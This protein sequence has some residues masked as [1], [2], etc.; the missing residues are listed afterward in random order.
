MIIIFL[1][2]ACGYA[3]VRYYV[4]V[5]ILYSY[6][7][8]VCILL[9]VCVSVQVSIDMYVCESEEGESNNVYLVR[10]NLVSLLSPS[11]PLQP[12]SPPLPV[13]LFN[14]AHKC[15]LQQEQRKACLQYFS[16]IH[17]LPP[18]S[19]IPRPTSTLTSSWPII[20][21]HIT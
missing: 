5:H 17:L 15:Q 18:G 3:C 14:P 8:V 16:G 1:P 21:C 6:I 12:P 20:S 10:L 2:C 13:G 7:C 9:C 19:K 11:L 4:Y